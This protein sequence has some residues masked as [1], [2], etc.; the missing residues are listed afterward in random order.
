[1]SHME[2]SISVII[3]T[4]ARVTQLTACLESF[5]RLQ[6]PPHRFDLIVVDDGTD[7]PIEPAIRDFKQHL[8]ML[9]LRQEQSGPAAARNRGAAHATGEY[10]AFT[11]DD[12]APAPDWLHALARKLRD[13]P[14]GLIGG[15]VL[16]NLPENTFTTASQLLVSYLYDYY[17]NEPG[18]ARFLTSNNMAVSKKLFDQIGGFDGQYCRAA[19]EDRDLCDR[20][21][22]E[23][24]RIIY[25]PDAVIRHS[26]A[27][28]LRSFWRQHFTYGRGAFQF[29]QAR[30]QRRARPL[31]VEPAS[32]YFNLVR[33]PMHYS[34]WPR[35]MLLA[36]LMALSQAAGT[37]GYFCERRKNISS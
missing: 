18:D 4:H 7:P 24:N 9:V 29:H 3:P 26:H 30:A 11:D 2:P 33:Y 25:T 23:G 16:N 10:L 8:N 5:T 17:N 28:T 15:Q 32:F 13:H 14:D 35:S 36:A 31:K 6:Y 34:S 22:H 19:A 12:C 20:W 37:A 27:L 1:M 21:L